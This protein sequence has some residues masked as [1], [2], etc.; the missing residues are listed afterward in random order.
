MTFKLWACFLI[1]LMGTYL[2]IA[3][4]ELKSLFD[5]AVRTIE[6]HKKGDLRTTQ[7]SFTEFTNSWDRQTQT[8]EY[9]KLVWIK[10]SECFVECGEYTKATNV[11][12]EVTRRTGRSLPPD[13]PYL[14]ARALYAKQEYEAVNGVLKKFAYH[15]KQ[16]PNN[17]QQELSIIGADTNEKLGNTR[18]VETFLEEAVR[19]DA[20]SDA[21]K[22]ANER[23]ERLLFKEKR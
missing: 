12:E 21:G 23:L 18:L 19:L 1:V 4:D 3:N 20:T 17:K 13:V 10:A 11:L 22:S 8:N 6:L 14:L 16:L 7:I 5:L 9:S 2:C 15:C